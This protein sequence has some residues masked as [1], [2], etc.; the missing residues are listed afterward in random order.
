M[1]AS[2]SN[3][4]DDSVNEDSDLVPVTMKASTSM[5]TR[6]AWGSVN[7]GTIGVKFEAGDTYDVFEA[8]HSGSHAFTCTSG[9]NTQ[10]ASFGGYWHGTSTTGCWAVGMPSGKVNNVEFETLTNRYTFSVPGTQTSVLDGSNVSPDRN[11]NILIGARN[12]QTSTAC[13]LTPVCAYLMFTS[14]SSTATIATTSKPIAGSAYA[15]AVNEFLSQPDATKFSVASTGGEAALKTITATGVESS[16]D[17]YKYVVCIIPGT[18]EAGDLKITCG[19]K[20]VSNTDAITLSSVN[21]YD[22]GT[23]STK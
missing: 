3:D 10:S 8:G 16:T 9:E 20:T 23:I 13:F 19:S 22:L 12:V 6:L 18:Y 14:S 21:V 5:E 17:V 7:S 2:C 1:F 4:N 15:V 11:A